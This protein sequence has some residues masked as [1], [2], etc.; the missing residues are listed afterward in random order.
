ML[1]DFTKNAM[2]HYLTKKDGPL[3][4]LIGNAFHYNKE[5]QSW[6]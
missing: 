3:P 5:T 6:Y 4:K 1:L 2:G